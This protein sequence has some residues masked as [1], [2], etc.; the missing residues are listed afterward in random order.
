MNPQM[1]KVISQKVSDSRSYLMMLVSS[2]IEIQKIEKESKMTLIGDL[3]QALEDL[4]M[5]DEV[6]EQTLGEK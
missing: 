1:N 6:L 3:N 2:L 4:A 5:L